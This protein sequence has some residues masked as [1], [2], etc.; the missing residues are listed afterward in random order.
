MVPRWW[1]FGEY[2]AQLAQERR[3]FAGVAWGIGKGM[4]VKG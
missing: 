2:R 1:S 3:S 4:I